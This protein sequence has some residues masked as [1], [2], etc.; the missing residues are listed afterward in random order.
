MHAVAGIPDSPRDEDPPG[1]SPRLRLRD[2]RRLDPDGVDGALGRFGPSS[3]VN[4]PASR[5]WTVEAGEPVV[6]RRGHRNFVSTTGPAHVTRDEIG[7]VDT[8]ELDLAVSLS[9]VHS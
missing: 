3:V 4:G 1:L 9:E 2:G 6:V 7:V 8:V 5:T